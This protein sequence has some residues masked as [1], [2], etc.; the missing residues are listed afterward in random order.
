LIPWVRR[1]LPGDRFDRFEG[2]TPSRYPCSDNKKIIKKDRVPGD[3]SNC[4]KRLS[5]Q[6]VNTIS[7]MK[8]KRMIPR[9]DHQMILP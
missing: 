5:P 7:T 3:M 2:T 1:T 6:R 8:P 9:I 4:W